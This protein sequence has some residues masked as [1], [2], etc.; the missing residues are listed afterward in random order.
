MTPPTTWAAGAILTGLVAAAIPSTATAGTPQPPAADA[1]AQSADALS[2]CLTD[3]G[4]PPLPAGAV[5]SPAPAGPSGPA[6]VV[7]VPAVGTITLPVPGTAMPAAGVST[8]TTGT[9]PPTAGTT[10]LPA[11][12]TPVAGTGSGGGAL[13]AAAGGSLQCGQFVINN[14]FV[15]VT[16]TTTTTNVDAPI[17]A[18]AGSISTTT[19]SAASPSI[20]RP[21]ATSAVGRPLRARGSARA[22]HKRA[23]KA[24]RVVRVRLSGRTGY[25][26]RVVRVRLILLGHAGRR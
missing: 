7:N 10:T 8:P 21:S 9:T 25:A 17:T 13:P 1:L 18:A 15:T 4:Y 6:P 14:Y 23:A 2:K 26:K 12:V 16:T 3:H 20:S 11:G 22:G 19:G 5:L 24:R